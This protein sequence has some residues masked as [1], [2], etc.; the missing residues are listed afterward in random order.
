MTNDRKHFFTFLIVFFSTLLVFNAKSL[1]LLFV[2]SFVAFYLILN[3]TLI[4]STFLTLLVSLPF[5]NSIR[6]WL[7]YNNP[8]LFDHYSLYF[9]ITIKLI[10]GLLL[11]L[12]LLIPKNRK[13][14]KKPSFSKNSILLSVFFILATFSSLFFRNGN[15]TIFM[16]YVQLILAL[17]YYYFAS[18]YFALPHKKNIFY[19]YVIALVIFS[20]TLGLMQFIKQSPTGKFIELTPSFAKS[21]GYVT[22]DGK[23][24]YRIA[25]FISHPV[26]FGSFMSILIPI[27][28]GIFLKKKQFRFLPIILLSILV[29]LETLSRSAWINLIIILLL[30]YFYQKNH[31]ISLPQIKVSKAIIYS[32]TSLVALLLIITIIPSLITRFNSIPNLLSD[33][34]GS[35]YSRLNLARAS[36][37]IT[38]NYPLFGVGLNGFTFQ[39]QSAPPHNTFLIF[40][41]EL[42]IPATIVF[43]IFVFRSIMPHLDPRKYQPISFGI[44]LSLITFIVSSQFHPL[45]NIDPTFDLFM[46]TLGFFATCQ[47]SKI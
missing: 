3:N 6:Q 10:F 21:T 8:N 2:F 9:G 27:V 45:F 5:E 19:V 22:T 15:I 35:L 38:A 42:G 30:F 14:F 44:W 24:Q 46:L 1:I 4:E 13:L 12:F 34:F 33:Q 11:L 39:N 36:I 23:A 31:P 17:L 7:I 37:K 16:G 26:Y 40:F 41:S 20:T 32:L 47:P 18:I 43:I 29:L 25:A 28:I